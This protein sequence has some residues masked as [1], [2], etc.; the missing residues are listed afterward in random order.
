[1]PRLLRYF[2]LI[3]PLCLACGFYSAPADASLN[4]GFVL[5]DHLGRSWRNECV[6]FPLSAKDRAQALDGKALVASNGVAAPYQLIEGDERHKD[7]WIAF[8]THLEP[9][10][11]RH[12]RFADARADTSTDLKIEESDTS[13]RISNRRVGIT[14]ARKLSGTNGPIAGIRLASGQWIGSS[15]LEQSPAVIVYRADVTARGPVFAEVVCRTTFAGGKAWTIRFRLQ[16]DEPVVLVDESFTAS[17]GGTFAVALGSE[18]AADSLF[19]RVPGDKGGSVLPISH[20]DKS[21][22][23]LLEPWLQWWGRE[24]G[25]WL[26]LFGARHPDMIVLGVRDPAAWIVPN[27]PDRSAG[28]APIVAQS[29][30]VSA[31]F[32]MQG[33]RKW[34]I[35]VHDRDAALEVTRKDAASAT[36]MPQRYLIKHADFPLDRMK[37][38]VLAWNGDQDRYPRLFLSQSELADIRKRFQLRPDDLQ[39]N[40]MA[41]LDVYSLDESLRYYL[42]TGDAELGRRLSQTA[43]KWIQE[44]VDAYFE[45]TSQVTL[46]FAPHHL[47]NKTLPALNLADVALA[48]DH[49]TP[50]QRIRLRAQIAFLAYTFNRDDFWSPER[51]FSANPNMTTTVAALRLATACL[52]PSHPQSKSWAQRALHELRDLELATWSDANGGWREAPHYAM[53][54]YDYLLG[55]LLMAKNAGLGDAV[56]DPRMRKIAEWFAKT[57]TPPDSAF[58]GRRHLPPIG[59]TWIREASGEFGIVAGIWKEKDPEFAAQMQ[60]MHRQ[61]GSLNVPG[62]GGFFPTLA[63]YRTL[64]RDNGIAPKAPAYGSEWFP[65]TGVVLRSGFASDRETQLLLIAGRNHD[66]YDHDS[67]GFTLWGRGRLLANDFGYNGQA[68]GA[69]HNLLIAPDAPESAL[70]HVQSFT[71]TDHFDYVLG[72]KRPEGKKGDRGWERRIV[73]VKSSE[74]AGSGYFVIRDSLPGGADGIWRLWLTARS[75]TPDGSLVH[76]DGIDDVDLD[77]FFARP[78]KPNLKTESKTQVAPGN[79]ATGEFQNAV[80]ITQTAIVAPARAGDSIVVVLQPRLKT[81]KRPIFTALADGKVVKVQSNAGTDYVLLGSSPFDFQEGELNFHGTAGAAQHCGKKY[82]LS[83]GEPGRV[84]MAGRVLESTRAASGTR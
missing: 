65:E 5:R 39:R 37:D 77:I 47:V 76:V 54:S 22:V 29:Q 45:Q 34:T 58:Q 14:V 68:P 57:S 63:G 31:R 75:V 16:A 71:T 70:M 78:D 33:E 18:F 19:C 28:P 49:L 62:A 40:R 25:T 3:S 73:F 53:V 42:G 26:G 11:F 81:E 6:T 1:M 60:W 51:A 55:C 80:S 41:P 20:T 44:V 32:A 2:V 27:E 10:E 9:Y 35:Q 8:R 12:Y 36:S 79:S 4:D 21:Q 48:G 61:H 69:D 15:T 50:E 72:V 17:V 24:R 59:N 66:H 23:F 56:F 84:S 30:S 38:Y 13:I 74:P 64:L 7:G 67:G 82:V 43:V 83:L 52:I 46:G